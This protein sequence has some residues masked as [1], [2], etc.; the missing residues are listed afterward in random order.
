M[1]RATSCEDSIASRSRLALIGAAIAYYAYFLY[2]TADGL[3][4]WF[5]ADDLLNLYY[6]WTHSVSEL[7]R[8]LLVPHDAYYRPM[9]GVF[10]KG[11]HA[12][13]GFT[14]LPFRIAAFALC[15]ANLWLMY[16]IAM[17][18]SS[19]KMIAFL[20]LLLG[21]TH[22][23]FV[24]LYYDTGMIYDVLAFFFYYLAF[25]LYVRGTPAVVV[26][27]CALAAIRSKEIALTLPAA[28]L[29]YDLI[30]RRRKLRELTA[31]A[32]TTALC[33]WF[34]VGRV[35]ADEP[36]LHHPGYA[37]HISA[38]TYLQTYGGYAIQ[39][40]YRAAPLSNAA[41]V[42]MLA[43][44]VALALVSRCKELMWSAAMMIVAPLPIAFIPARNGFAFVVPG[45][46]CFLFVAAALMWIAR[47]PVIQ[48]ITVALVGLFVLREHAKM[49]QYPLPIVHDVQNKNRKYQAQLFS[50]L[51]SLK[52]GATVLMRND[53]FSTA[54]QD[55][56]FLMA[57]SYND[58]T[59]RV[60]R[61][62]APPANGFAERYDYVLD[63]V[64]DRFI[65]VS[66]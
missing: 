3:R 14:A 24:S 42:A 27:L 40:L 63:F 44:A 41:M 7:V 53:P 50:V 43:G 4:S 56:L 51:P 60:D 10:Y 21:G 34:V 2:F 35:L 47:R 16:R 26:V 17:L 55:P 9:G 5:S 23:A 1:G 19:S 11:I 66:K 13:F 33:L 65:V 54:M 36:L 59:L 8:G 25:L 18:L 48:A 31:L 45:L 58:R 22:A 49:F 28:F 6:Y 62:K 12:L 32:A 20:V 37:P 61:V 39:L 52:R 46:P 29:A 15:T 30:W 57:L 38:T 64:D